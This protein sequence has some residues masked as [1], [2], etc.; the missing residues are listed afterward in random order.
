MTDSLIPLNQPSEPT[1]PQFDDSVNYLEQV[2]GEGGKFYDPDRNKALEK[3]A[4]GKLHSDYYVP[5]LEKRLDQMRN[6]YT[7]ANKQLL[8]GQKLQDL[9]DKMN[10]MQPTNSNSYTPPANDPGTPAVPDMAKVQSLISEEISRDRI[11]REQEQNY[12]Y[13]KNK[14]EER[15]GPNYGSELD[16]QYKELGLTDQIAAQMARTAPKALERML[17]LDKP[18]Q[19]QDFQAPPQNT[20]RRDSLGTP[21]NT[22]GAKTWA[23]WQKVKQTDPKLYYSKQAAAQME[24]DYATLGD[25][26]ENGDFHS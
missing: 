8:A 4:R 15:Y 14:L 19:Q 20:S 6:D 11:N 3:L 12:N 24:K 23:E 7:E 2:I 21:R 26:F 18:P 25:S 22:S 16:K 17:G 5:V 9:I 13:V 10:T 1:A